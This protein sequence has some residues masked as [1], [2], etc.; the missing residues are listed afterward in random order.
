MGGHNSLA[1]E[2]RTCLSGRLELKGLKYSLKK[3][4]IVLTS[5]E[6]KPNWPPPLVPEKEKGGGGGVLS[7][8]SILNQAV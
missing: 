6:D 2:K 5:K 8:S 3:R 7:A 4:N 1:E